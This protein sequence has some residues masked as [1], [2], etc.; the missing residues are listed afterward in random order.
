MPTSFLV[1]LFV[2]AHVL[3]YLLKGHVFVNVSLKTPH[4]NIFT[5]SGDSSLTSMF[6]MNFKHI[7]SNRSM[8][9][10]KKILEVYLSG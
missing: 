8:D 2:V 1:Q 6:V 3:T 10:L 9:R 4:A 5:P 7:N